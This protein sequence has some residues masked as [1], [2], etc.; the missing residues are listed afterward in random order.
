MSLL[1][2][3]LEKNPENRLSS[4]KNSITDRPNVVDLMDSTV[5]STQASD[6]AV[7]SFPDH[8]MHAASAQNH[9]NGRSSSSQQ[10]QRTPS[11]RHWR[12]QPNIGKYKLIRTLGRGN[13][14][15]V[16]L[17]EHVSTGR[18]VAVKVIDKTQ[19]NRAS[20]LKLFR[21]VKIMK[22]LNHP[23]I[24]RLYEVIESERHVYLVMEYAPNGEVF[25]YLVTNG[26]M[27]E[28]EARAKFRQLVSAVEYCHWKKIVHRD[29]KAENLLLD[30][31]YNIK[32]ADFGFSNFYD[33]EHKLD[34]FCGSP[35]YAAPE[36]FQ[37]QKYFGPEVDVWSLG[38][39]LYTLVSGSLPF[40][41]Q[42][43]KELQSRVI[44]GKYR[45]PF[46]MSTDCELLLRKLLVLN[47]AKRKPLRVI[48]TDKWL[49]MGYEEEILEPYV[50][51]PPDYHDSVRL[52]IM[53][54]MGY[55]S[56]EV[57]EALE[58]QSFNNVT[59]IYLLLSDPKTQANLPAQSLT[60]SKRNSRV[61]GNLV[62]RENSVQ[63]KKIV[64]GT[65]SKDQTSST[66]RG[67]EFSKV[68]ITTPSRSLRS[69][70]DEVNGQVSSEA[71]AHAE[72][73][74]HVGV[75]W[76]K[77]SASAGPTSSRSERPSIDERNAH[78]IPKIQ[79]SDV[80][81]TG[82]NESDS[83]NHDDGT[84]MESFDAACIRRNNT[85]TVKKI[86][87]AGSDLTPPDENCPLSRAAQFSNIPN[88]L[89]SN[90]SQIFE[91]KGD[92]H[93]DESLERS[94]EENEVQ[95]QMSKAEETNYKVKPAVPYRK[96]NP[97]LGWIRRT[98]SC[99]RPRYKPPPTA[100]TTDTSPTVRVDASYNPEIVDML[101][102]IERHQFVRNCSERATVGIPTYRAG[103]A[104]DRRLPASGQGGKL[105]DTLE[106]TSN[107]TTS[108]ADTLN[109]SS[110][111]TLNASP[112]SNKP[113]TVSSISPA[114]TPQQVEPAASPRF[115]LPTTL[116]TTNVHRDPLSQWSM[117]LKPM[118]TSSGNKSARQTCTESTVAPVTEN[119]G[120][121]PK[122]ADADH[123]STSSLLALQPKNHEHNKDG[124]VTQVHNLHES[125]SGHTLNVAK[126]YHSGN[127]PGQ[128]FRM[129]TSRLSRSHTSERMDKKKQRRAA[130][131]TDRRSFNPALAQESGAGKRLSCAQEP[132]EQDA[133]GSPSESPREASNPDPW[134]PMRNTQT[135]TPISLPYASG[136]EQTGQSPNPDVGVVG[137]S[138]NGNRRE[139]SDDIQIACGRDADSFPTGTKQQRTGQLPS[140]FSASLPRRRNC[141]SPH[142]QEHSASSTGSGKKS[143][144]PRRLHFVYRL[145]VMCS[146]AQA[147]LA[148][149]IRVLESNR[150]SYTTRTNFCFLCTNMPNLHP[151]NNLEGGDED[152]LISSD[153]NSSSLRWEVEIC[154][155][156]KPN[157][158][159]VKF[160]RI[161]GDASEFKEI[162]RNLLQQ[163]TVQ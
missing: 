110:N 84:E 79:L 24:V 81:K 82:P 152:Q 32:L 140:A 27:K 23:N 58:N 144:K 129:L 120:L 119:S 161:A 17:A 153:F 64:N 39:I 53:E 126:P 66:E 159:G 100:T 65:S 87:P 146:D 77:Q 106:S 3:T 86:R 160:K 28:K 131:S 74:K 75:S 49:N 130:K 78:G 45:V 97:L 9:S 142:H 56:S 155:L 8:Q 108:R 88:H 143:S 25:D 123:S 125:S 133:R 135:K 162:E 113:N 34:T 148:D 61:E 6:I 2:N 111:N 107:S 109:G 83:H 20:L 57:I 92:L 36:L 134:T 69:P 94:S 141:D 43:L 5:H 30:K 4:P 62:I 72:S 137:P 150:I 54:K 90:P 14:A 117:R 48:M 139:H 15:K 68:T 29:L 60:P 128:F 76:L 18:Q 70:T 124:D 114:V 59:A 158:Y 19:L 51:P 11:R 33:G 7:E 99:H 95:D 105:A 145:P 80:K 12:D 35:P 103:M 115:K 46:Y 102:P 63:K 132:T 71:S 26:K 91:E 154:K 157:R 93:A 40:D 44:R 52:A 1:D 10:Q 136:V 127:G 122:S 156:H 73:K 42:H 163:F 16:K 85:F 121:T 37:G 55:K 118:G 149:T 98:F 31:D 96:E 67:E 104:I 116:P 138:S 101:N 47:P 22:M 147:L 13:F 21:E 50:E 89:T 38:V 151:S 112:T 41:A